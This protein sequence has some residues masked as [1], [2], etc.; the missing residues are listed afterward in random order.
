MFLKSFTS[1][2]PIF[3]ID[4]NALNNYLIFK[5][6]NFMFS[7]TKPNFLFFEFG[8]NVPSTQMKIMLEKAPYN[9]A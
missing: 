9:R 3:K 6:K 2:S 5:K 7:E 8:S 4:L 1:Y